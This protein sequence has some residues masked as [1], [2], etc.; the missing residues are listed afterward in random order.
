MG[1]VG[2]PDDSF[3]QEPGASS[4]MPSRAARRRGPARLLA[5]NRATG[6]H[7][8]YGSPP[9]YWVRSHLET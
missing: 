4:T 6:S 5:R 9:V 1:R 7:P 3:P 2:G 8:G